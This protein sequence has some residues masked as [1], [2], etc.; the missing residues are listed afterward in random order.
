MRVTD[1]GR[2]PDAVIN[3]YH[4][5]AVVP[6]PRRS[7]SSVDLI[8]AR[9]FA[10]GPKQTHAIREWARTQG[11]H[12]TDRGRIPAAVIDAYRDRAVPHPRRSDA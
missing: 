11:M 3:A 10:S 7:D 6:H 4:D 5:Q 9:R 2:I 1:R 8:A 12:V